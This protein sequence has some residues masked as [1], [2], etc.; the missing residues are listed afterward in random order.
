MKAHSTP[1]QSPALDGDNERAVFPTQRALS[2]GLPPTS[3][4]KEPN[5]EYHAC[6][7]GQQKRPA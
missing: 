1:N 6:E 3:E 5:T 7:D 2:F 4:R